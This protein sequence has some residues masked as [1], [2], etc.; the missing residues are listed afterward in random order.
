[1]SFAADRILYLSVP[2]VVK[3]PVVRLL[4]LCHLV[5][6][7]AK[8]IVARVGAGEVAPSCEHKKAAPFFSKARQLIGSSKLLVLS[9]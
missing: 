2:Y 1:M 6:F 3:P 9:S 4:F 5:L 7:V 8:R